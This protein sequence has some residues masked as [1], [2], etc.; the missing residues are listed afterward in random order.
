MCSR[1]HRAGGCPS[2]CAATGA[3]AS[4]LLA[5]VLG[6]CVEPTES[7]V[8]DQVLR[9]RSP[10]TVGGCTCPT[11]GGCSTVS[12]A[13]IPSD[14]LYYITTFGGGSDTQG[15]ACGGTADGTWAYIANSAR[16]G[17]GAKVKIEANG[18]ACIAKVADCGPNRCVEQAASYSSCQSHHPIIDASPLI[19]K[20]LFGLSGMGWS[21]KKTVKA[22][23][24][25]SSA[26]S[27]SPPDTDGAGVSDS[28]DNCPS[29]KNADQADSD[30]N[31]VGDA[32]DTPAPTLPEAKLDAG[33]PAPQDGMPASSS[34]LDTSR[35]D[36]LASGELGAVSA[37]LPPSAGS[38]LGRRPTEGCA[39][40]GAP[41][42]SAGL[43]FVL[44]LLLLARLRRR[45]C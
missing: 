44:A 43:A 35:G 40:A 25:A 23:L 4:I 30:L 22:T 9:W 7:A 21:D 32:C 20:H 12:Y 24:A 38:A 6:A 1:G 3:A 17:C 10:L 8:E 15:M 27:G 31:G 18:K 45:T 5:L 37:D 33:A 29:T 39:L 16:F 28:S 42:E 2:P 13:D 11:S 34:D 14:N 41:S 26:P 36:L 19:T